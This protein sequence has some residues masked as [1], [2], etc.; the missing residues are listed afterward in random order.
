VVGGGGRLIRIIFLGLVSLQHFR[1]L[2]IAA[3]FRAVI[4]ARFRLFCSLFF[5]TCKRNQCKFDD[6]TERVLS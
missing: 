3:A 1:L 5:G 2:Q 4:Y 6:L